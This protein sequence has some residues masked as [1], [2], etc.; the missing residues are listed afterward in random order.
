MLCQF[1]F[2]QRADQFTWL[3]TALLYQTLE[4][5]RIVANQAEHVG[6]RRGFERHVISAR[7]A[8]ARQADFLEDVLGRFDQLG[9]VAY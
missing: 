2:E 1:E 8:A 7:G 4:I 9:A 3:P 5:D 6:V